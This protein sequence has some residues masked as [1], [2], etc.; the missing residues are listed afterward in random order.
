MGKGPEQTY[1]HRQYPNVTGT[2]K[3][4]QHCQSL[5]KYSSKP[6]R[7]IIS[8]LLECPLSKKTR[9]NKCW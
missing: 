5:G 4:T 8:P 7:G 3:G 1:F 2:C 9:E 6:Q